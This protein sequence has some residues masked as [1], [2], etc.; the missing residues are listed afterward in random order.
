MRKLLYF[1]MTL[2]VGLSLAACAPGLSAFSLQDK[3]TIEAIVSDAIMDWVDDPWLIGELPVEGHVI[4]D[5]ADKGETLEVYVIDCYGGM[6][7]E[8]DCFVLVSGSYDIPAVVTLQKEA[9]GSYSPADYR[10]AADGDMYESSLN[11]MFPWYLRITDPSHYRAACKG[12]MLKQAE[13][14]LKSIGKDARIS[15]SYV[16]KENFHIQADAYNVLYGMSDMYEYPDWIGTYENIENGERFIY[17]SAE[18]ILPD[19][20]VII[21]FTKERPDGSVVQEL[22]YKVQGSQWELLK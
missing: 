12:Q 13:N 10:E 19:D 22:R 20:A 2:V 15:F 17:K 7:F 3:E 18:E 14:Y 21:R 11:E 5:A 8:N 6:G 4:L 1:F 16:E 9:D